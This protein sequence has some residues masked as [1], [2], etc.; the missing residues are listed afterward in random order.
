MN[1]RERHQV[2]EAEPV[3]DAKATPENGGHPLLNLQRAAGNAAVNR[4]IQT[5]LTVGHA[6]D[7][8]EREADRVAAEVVQRIRAGEAGESTDDVQRSTTPS[9]QLKSADPLGGSP[10]PGDIEQ[11]ISGSS[12]RAMDGGT[13]SRMEG[14]FGAD[15]SSVRVHTGAE[16]ATLSE[17]LQAK[18]FTTG[19]D[20]FFGKGAY[21][22]ASSGGQELLAHE[23]THVVQQNGGTANRQ[24]RRFVDAKTF[25]AR[26][27]EGYFT[28]E[29]TAQKEIVKKLTAYAALGVKG[30]TGQVTIP[31]TKLRQA[32]DLILSMK[33]AANNWLDAHTVDE[34]DKVTGKTVAKVDSSRQNRAAGMAW[35][36]MA[37]DQELAALEN[38]VN[39]AAEGVTQDE[40]V[41]DTAGRLALKEHYQGNLSGTLQNISKLIEKV[42]PNDG[43]S[44]ELSVEVQIPVAPG[45]FVGGTLGLE[46]ER[47]DK[48]VEVGCEAAFV[49]KGSAGIADIAGALGGYI[50][51]KGPG[52]E[53]VM[54]LISYGFYRRIK[55]S[56][57]IPGEI[58]S[59]IWGG[60]TSD[61][62]K[63]KADKWSLEVEKLLLGKAAEGEEE[64]DN[65]VE[66]GG[67]ASVGATLDGGV[68]EAELEA[69]YSSGKRY[70]AQSMEAR[71]GGA[72]KENKK[73]D[74]FFTQN[75]AS[76]VGRG[77]EKSTGR[78]THNLGLSATVSFLDGML[79]GG[80]GFEASWRSQG[81]HA[82]ER[83]T[84]PDM[85]LEDLSITLSA[86]GTFPA[87]GI[88]EKLIDL[89]VA[90]AADG[91]DKAGELTDKAKGEEEMPKTE[92]A[93]AKAQIQGAFAS[94]TGVPFSQ[95]YADAISGAKDDEPEVEGA[96]PEESLLESTVGLEVGLELARDK[97]GKWSAEISLKHKKTKT[98]K[99]PELLEIELVRASTLGS[100]KYSNGAW[101]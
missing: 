66:L 61:F 88:E 81:Q 47:D 90:V 44:V 8:H 5:K 78:S 30:K 92:M 29:S 31:D 23:L 40:V 69:K 50:K 51:A 83:K 63:K 24:I 76:K 26:T 98:V 18:A 65:Y 59:L 4:L 19:N 62:A 84:K 71:K 52:G 89:A 99:L 9:L 77:A 17:S 15:L 36:F 55:E 46:A 80:M 79:G 86:E 34:V 7:P 75:V 43:D 42:V 58:S 13:L 49:A 37:A 48:A 33:D 97:A 6:G 53:G 67:L 101:T 54:K 27:S 94:I 22:P 25:S 91:K 28:G 14:A 21:D 57:I 16:A 20:V 41:P 35:F 96:E 60:G 74:S 45:V 85:L 72:G 100:A 3:A 1:D 64:N 73:S 70:D 93:I 95:W 56:S 12:G 39:T 10:V 38:R 11:R 32:M 2:L 68:V 87:G 82:E